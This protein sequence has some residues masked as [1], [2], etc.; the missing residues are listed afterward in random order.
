MNKCSVHTLLNALLVHS[1]TS[2]MIQAFE[3]IEKR[4]EVT[5]AAP[6]DTSDIDGAHSIVEMARNEP[7]KC[8]EFA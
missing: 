8:V 4:S 1:Q 2:K 5:D 3:N 6:M 7:I